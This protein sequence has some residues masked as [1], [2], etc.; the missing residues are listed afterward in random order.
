[1]KVKKSI[2]KPVPGEKD[3]LGEIYRKAA[4]I[5]F[6][7][8][9]DATS[10]N[11]IAA[12]VGMTKAGIYHYIEGKQDLLFAINSFGLDRLNNKVIHPASQIADAEERLRFIVVNHAKLI[13]EVSGH[14]TIL[15]DEVAGLA[16]AQRRAI[17]KRRRAYLDFLRSTLRELKEQG[18]LRDID[19]TVAAFSIFGMLLWLSRWYTAGGRLTSDQ[20]AQEIL[21]IV[22][23]GFLVTE[24][25]SP[26]LS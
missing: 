21:K 20:V 2:K 16:P 9:Y 5:I 3:R 10:M 14:I 1:M 4:Q 7:K 26:N 12:A 19:I 6:E 24:T 17:D 13:T 25:P 11:D 15:I 18:K 23:N 22:V 8:G